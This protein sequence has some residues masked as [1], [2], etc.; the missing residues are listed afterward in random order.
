MSPR[1]INK[2]PGAIRLD[3]FQN[4]V[5]FA[6]T[7]VGPTTVS[8]YFAL[9][10]SNNTPSLAQFDINR[11]LP[12]LVRWQITNGTPFAV[13]L[14]G[15]GSEPLDGDRVD[16]GTTTVRLIGAASNLPDLVMPVIDGVT[17]DIVYFRLGNNEGAPT[18]PG[19]ST[20]SSIAY[21]NGP[22]GIRPPGDYGYPAT[23]TD[24]FGNRYMTGSDGRKYS[25]PGDEPTW[26]SEST[27]LFG[28]PFSNYHNDIS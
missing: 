13:P 20:V 26:D 5:N 1:L 8:W 17:Q 2:G 23:S 11:S 27:S 18:D 9:M 25:W 6:L 28:T 24:V 12:G 22:L 15:P 7:A 10:F 19:T 4:I 3:P 14:F 21:L 16:Y